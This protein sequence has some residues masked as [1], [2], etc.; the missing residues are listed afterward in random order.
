[1]NTEMTLHTVFDGQSVQE[2]LVEDYVK[3]GDM[4]EYCPANQEG[5]TIYRVIEKDGQKALEHLSDYY[6]SQLD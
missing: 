2:R 6:S 1:M 4:I 3:V 5:W